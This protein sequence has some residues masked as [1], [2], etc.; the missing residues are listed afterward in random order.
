MK[1][2]GGKYFSYEG[3]PCS[4]SSERQRTLSDDF[5]SFPVPV[6]DNIFLAAPPFKPLPENEKDRWKFLAGSREW[7][8]VMKSN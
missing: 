6:A 5:L 8:P 3:I 7:P 1:S 4:E 2:R